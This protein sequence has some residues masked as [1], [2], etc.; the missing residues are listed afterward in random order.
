MSRL[1]IIRDFKNGMVTLDEQTLPM[2]D[3][4][5]LRDRNQM[6]NILYSHSG[7]TNTMFNTESTVTWELTDRAAR[8]LDPDYKAAYLPTLVDNNCAHLIKADKS[9]L[10]ELLTPLKQLF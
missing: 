5:C 6:Y 10:L 2:L 1:G 4:K 7:E 3:I 9:E 8:I